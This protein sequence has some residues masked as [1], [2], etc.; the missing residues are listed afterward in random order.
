M[1]HQ[2]L[3]LP[4]MEISRKKKIPLGKENKGSESTVSKQT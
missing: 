2:I 4:K 3:M 1:G